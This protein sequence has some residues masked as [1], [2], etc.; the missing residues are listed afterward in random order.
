MPLVYAF[1]C[2]HHPLAQIQLAR[3]KA[4]DTMKN[5]LILL[6]ILLLC[7]CG[8]RYYSKIEK[9]DTRVNWQLELL[10]VAPEE[11]VWDAFYE[12]SIPK[13]KAIQIGYDE[14]ISKCMD[15]LP[16]ATMSVA[17]PWGCNAVYV[18]REWFERKQPFDVFSWEHDRIREILWGVPGGVSIMP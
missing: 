7:G 18:S 17:A 8:V 11:Q 10:P 2:G 1:V 16:P 15:L 13:S 4:E 12:K 9:A 6:A 5:A 14:F 3:S